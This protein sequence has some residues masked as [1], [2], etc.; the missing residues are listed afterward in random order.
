[1]THAEVAIANVADEQLVRLASLRQ[2]DAF[3]ELIR[4]HQRKCVDLACSV[5]RNR[6]DAEDATQDAF[7]KAYT[8]LDQ[9]SGD[10]A[11]ATWLA[12]IVFNECLMLVRERGRVRMLYL[13]EVRAEPMAHPVELPSRVPDPE[14]QLA[15][16]EMLDLLKMEICRIPP[17]LRNVILLRDIQELP[18]TSVAD[19]LGI[20]VPAVKSRLLRARTELRVHL[21]RHYGPAAA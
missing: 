5:L 20:T 1:M 3:N 4:R 8:H 10:A 17:L 11:F 2:S 15:K 14:R 7:A 9:Y 19:M 13:D 18:L 16:Q 6:A 12:R 21:Q